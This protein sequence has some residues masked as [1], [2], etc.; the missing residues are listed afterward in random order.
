MRL[1][2][3][4]CFDFGGDRAVVG[5]DLV[6][7]E[8]WDAL[9]TSTDGPFSIAGDRSELERTAESRPE[10][11]ERAR[12]IDAVLEARATRALA[13]YGV[14]GAVLEVCLE[15][16]RPQRRLTLTD[17]GPETVERLRQLFPEANVE[18]HDLREDPPLA[19]DIH[20]FHRIDTEFTNREWRDLLRRFQ[21]ESI[22]V[23]AT[24]IAD[25]ERV[26]RELVGRFR[27]RHLTQAGWLR[28]RDAF[29]ALWRPTHA[30]TPLR[31][32]DLDG[33]LLEPRVR[34][35]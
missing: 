3:R 28:T 17:Y 26:A 10:I 18:Q 13:S 25:L 4:H 27:N 7:P 35:T 9:R 30:A 32:H 34:P 8:A 12:Q 16:L 5:D 1:T 22:L 20:L 19:A 2:V 24:E 15:R 6:R 33:W 31:L 11:E 21:R 23:V 14:G 29:D